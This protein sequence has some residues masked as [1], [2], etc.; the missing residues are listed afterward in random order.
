MG[1]VQQMLL[2]VTPAA[3]PGGSMEWVGLGTPITDEYATTT[4]TASV[5]AGLQVG[6]MLLF[7][8]NDYVDPTEVEADNGQTL[9]LLT[10]YFTPLEVCQVYG[11]I[12][13][14]TIPT[15]VTATLSAADFYQAQCVAARGVTQSAGAKTNGDSGSAR[16]NLTFNTDAAEVL[17]LL[18]YT[19][20]GSTT[21]A[22][23]AASFAGGGGLDY[24][25]RWS[26]DVV[27]G[28][29][30]GKHNG[31]TG[32]DINVGVTWND[33]ADTGGRWMSL[34]LKP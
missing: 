34:A 10:R 29:F 27:H 16:A 15:S 25:S 21:R 19:T 32:S 22:V 26:N 30:A 4:P 33:A 13:A 5:P 3:P 11:V 23:S 6:D 1:A 20:P 18:M 12:V 24:G 2:G 17:V 9:E 14:G 31:S 28:L 7:V 8:T